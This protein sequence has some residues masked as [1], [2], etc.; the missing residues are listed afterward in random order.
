MSSGINFTRVGARSSIL[1]GT[2]LGG[3]IGSMAAEGVDGS[4]SG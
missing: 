4:G 2:L 1:V 3:S